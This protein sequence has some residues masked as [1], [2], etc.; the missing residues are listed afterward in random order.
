MR[1]PG[2]FVNISPIGETLGAMEQEMARLEG[3]TAAKNDQLAVS[4]ADAGLALW[5]RDYG[6]SSA[7]DLPTRRGRIRAAMTAGAQPF[8]LAA[9]RQLA[10]TVGGA[11]GVA[12]EEDFANARVVIRAVFPDAAGI[13]ALE[14]ALRRFM[15]AHLQAV[16]NPT[17]E[18]TGTVKLYPVLSGGIYAELTGTAET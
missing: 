10:I 4:T 14:E 2:F 15:P 11:G 16:V 13:P 9:L 18:L 3:E 17:V 1:L 5:E 8:T 12:V 7:G 6:L